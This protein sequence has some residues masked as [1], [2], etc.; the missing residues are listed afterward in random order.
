MNMHLWGTDRLLS[1]YL[2]A[3]LALAML[4]AGEMW[5]VVTLSPRNS[6]TWAFSIVWGGGTSLLWDK[7][8]A[9]AEEVLFI[10]TDAACI[11]FLAT[12]EIRTLSLSL[13]NK[14]MFTQNARDLLICWRKMVIEYMWTLDPRGKLQ[15]LDSQCCSKMCS[16]SEK[17]KMEEESLEPSPDLTWGR[18]TAPVQD[19]KTLEASEDP[20]LQPSPEILKDGGDDSFLFSLLDLVP[21]RPDIT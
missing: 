12:C 5:S 19:R 15:N 3:A 11:V 18:L 7:R 8:Q 2:A 4:P 14:R 17:A 9:E 1:R 20:H 13:H 6:K 10:S 16:L 21:G